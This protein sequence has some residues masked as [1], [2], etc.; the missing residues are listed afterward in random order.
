M[1]V[2]FVGFVVRDSFI[3]ICRYFFCKEVVGV[4]V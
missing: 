4:R 2:D 1:L 3:F